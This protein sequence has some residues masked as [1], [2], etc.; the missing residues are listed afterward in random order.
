M[1]P[2][3]NR[4]SVRHGIAMMAAVCAGAVALG[5]ANPAQASTRGSVS[6][7][8]GSRDRC[9]EPRCAP[10]VR[11]VYEVRVDCDYERGMSVGKDA[12]YDAGFRDGVRAMCYDACPT[13]SFCNVNASFERGY[14]AA[15]ARAYADGFARGK[16][17]RCEIRPHRPVCR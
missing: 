7:S 12:G 10:P 15:F 5:A 9:A 1:N 14:R 13:A 6:I 4:L 16:A 8:F 17:E 11:R 3:R 2:F